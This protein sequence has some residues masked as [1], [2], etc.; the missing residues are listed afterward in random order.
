MADIIYLTLK[1]NRKG[2]ISAG[3]SGYDSIGNKYQDK[4]KDQIFVYSTMYDL[5]R[6]QNVAHAPF[7]L[8]KAD[9]KSSPLCFLPYQIMS[10]RIA[11]LI[12]IVLI[13]RAY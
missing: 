11:S 10:F 3:C 13:S 5:F 7:L 2:L 12:I 6:Q 8:V 1:G 4:H 9:D